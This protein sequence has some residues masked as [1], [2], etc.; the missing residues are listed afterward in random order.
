M[1]PLQDAANPP[2]R[3]RAETGI[4]QDAHL[5]NERRFRCCIHSLAL[6]QIGPSPTNSVLASAPYRGG[7]RSRSVQSPSRS[8][9][10]CIGRWPERVRVLS[11]QSVRGSSM[12]R[13]RKELSGAASP[14]TS[15][16]TAASDG[17]FRFPETARNPSDSRARPR[18]HE[19]V[20]GC[21][22][23]HDSRDTLMREAEAERHMGE[24]RPDTERGLHQDTGDER[25]RRWR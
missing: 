12:G 16:P 4:E 18:R 22:A 13:Y 10:R 15:L 17:F 23:R 20:P 7:W 9:G 25:E 11:L 2:F 21:D 8:W 14:H 6:Q 5:R 3:D 1:K 19:K 24:Q